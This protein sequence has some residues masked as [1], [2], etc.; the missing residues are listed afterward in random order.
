MVTVFASQYYAMSRSFPGFLAAGIV[1]LDDEEAQFELVK[2][3]WDEFGLGDPSRFHR[4]LFRRFLAS[5]GVT[6]PDHIAASASTQAYVRDMTLLCMRGAP[7]EI[8]G[9]L[10]PGCEYVTPAEYQ[11]IRDGLLRSRLFGDDAVEFFTDHIAHDAGHAAGLTK[12]I[13]RLSSG[14]SSDVEKGALRALELERAFWDGVW[15][16]MVEAR[17]QPEGVNI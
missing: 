5:C 6:D 4:Q 15:S 2:N 7:A 8:L 11:I 17:G 1:A 9:A 10:G 16:L 12:A 3:L 13:T 14:L